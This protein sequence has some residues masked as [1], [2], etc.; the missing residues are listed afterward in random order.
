MSWATTCSISWD[1]RPRSLWTAGSH[2]EKRNRIY[3]CSPPA[4]VKSWLHGRKL[5]PFPRG[6]RPG[7]RV[8]LAEFHSSRATGQTHGRRGEVDGASMTKGPTGLHSSQ[9][10]CFTRG[11]VEPHT[12]GF[13]VALV[14]EVV[15]GSEDSWSPE[16][17]QGGAWE[18]SDVVNDKERGFTQAD[19]LPHLSIS[20]IRSD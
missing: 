3:V 2:E 15:R 16:N 1:Y 19:A 13:T 7:G 20:N 6:P 5:P 10:N 14:K 12:V 17:A 8:G 4:L 9:I 18:V 11:W